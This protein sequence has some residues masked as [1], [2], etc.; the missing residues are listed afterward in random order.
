MLMN[1]IFSPVFTHNDPVIQMFNIRK[2][3][4]FYS[5]SKSMNQVH[6]PGFRLQIREQMIKK[7]AVGAKHN[8]IQS[9][10]NHLGD[11]SEADIGCPAFLGKKGDVHA[12]SSPVKQR[13]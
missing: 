1:E 10:V 11:N 9:P 6:T 2:T 8:R 12:I 3:H 4:I 7:I 5:A 13:P